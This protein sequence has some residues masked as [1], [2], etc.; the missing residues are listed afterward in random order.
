[1][2]AHAWYFDIISP[3]AY[4]QWRRLR[5]DYPHVWLDPRPVVFAGL[6]DHW[7]QLGPA[8]IAEK[9]K[10]T[11]R[12]ALWQARQLGMPLQFPP[13]HPFNPLPSLRLILAAQDIH[14]ATDAVFAHVWEY[15]RAGDSAHALR[16]V[17]N[18]LGIV[19][20]EAAIADPRIKQALTDN[21]REA[22]ARGVF[23]VPT[24]CI[25]DQPFWG[26]DATELALAYRADPLMT[27]DAAMR[28]V[29]TLPA[30]IQR[31]AVIQ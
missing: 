2:S 19:D 21:G 28:A 10:H 8:E 31:K 12:L 20:V 18:L 4:L 29:E 3:F 25:G 22:I 13:A 6:L 14:A 15:G 16:D 9:R 24:L 11:Y 5:R 30:A 27:F 26:N 1:M 23:G 17:G 7:G